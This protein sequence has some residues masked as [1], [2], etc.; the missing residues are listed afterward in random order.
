MFEGRYMEHSE[1]DGNMLVVSKD[2]SVVEVIQ[3][4]ET[5]I[6]RDP[7]LKITQEIDGR[8]SR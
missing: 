3:Q 5:Q 4:W 6:K 7:R 8:F 2:T 1:K